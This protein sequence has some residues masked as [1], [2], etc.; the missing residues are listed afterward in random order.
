MHPLLKKFPIISDQIEPAELSLILSELE[1]V[2]SEGIKGQV[3]EFGCYVGTT[4]LFMQR[5]IL[6]LSPQKKLFVYDSFAGLPEKL[7]QDIN[8]S[9]TDFTAGE[10]KTSKAE[11]ILN[12]KKAG[13]KIPF[14]KK[15]WFKDLSLDDIPNQICFAFLDGDFYESILQPLNLIKNNLTKGATIIID[16]YGNEKLPGAKRAADQF[17]ASQPNFKL[18]QTSHSL[19]VLTFC[20]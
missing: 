4:S 6:S 2:L 15:A 5:L 20:G 9:G 8:A 16:D 11:L 14:I 1:D 3:C 19:A 10:L 17:L 12:F 13:L 18:G 7:Y